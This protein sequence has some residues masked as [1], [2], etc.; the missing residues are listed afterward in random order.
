[1]RIAI[2]GVPGLGAEKTRDMFHK[3][4]NMYEYVKFPELN[5]SKTDIESTESV[6]DEVIKFAE[7]TLQKIKEYTKFEDKVLYETIPLEWLMMAIRENEAGDFSDEGVKKL[8]EISNES[9]KYLDCVY[10]IPKSK[11]NAIIDTEV[12][13]NV[14]NDI[15][16][17]YDMIIHSFNYGEKCIFFNLN[18]CPGFIEIFGD[19]E[20]KLQM[21]KMYLNEEGNLIEDNLQQL[22]S[23]EQIEEGQ[24]ILEAELKNQKA[25]QKKEAFYKQLK[26]YKR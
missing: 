16:Q 26:N 2:I 6:E 23:P 24:K 12:D 5:E 17:L 18:D 9:L 11:Y 20:Q 8:F 25:A 21:F 7:K 19:D 14:I 3:N 10:M 1:M 22:F 13:Q 4:W 15:G